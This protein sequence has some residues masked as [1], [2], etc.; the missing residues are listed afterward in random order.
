MIPFSCPFEG[1][2]FWLCGQ[3]YQKP[4]DN[5]GIP[6][7]HYLTITQASA[8]LPRPQVTFDLEGYRD[9]TFCLPV[10]SVLPMH[11]SFHRYQRWIILK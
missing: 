3:R 6:Q 1:S 11:P 8:P 4:S 7:S 5:L 2:Y 9:L 10:P